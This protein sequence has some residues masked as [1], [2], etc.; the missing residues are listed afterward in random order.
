M[1]CL[2]ICA[3]VDMY[4]KDDVQEFFDKLLALD[5][6]TWSALTTGYAQHG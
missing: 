2:E 1:S 4:S 5:V 3:L 6:F